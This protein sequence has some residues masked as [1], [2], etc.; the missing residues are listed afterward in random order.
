MTCPFSSHVWISKSNFLSHA[1]DAIL[2]FLFVCYNKFCFYDFHEDPGSV[3]L[4]PFFLQTMQSRECHPSAWNWYLLKTSNPGTTHTIWQPCLSHCWNCLHILTIGCLCHISLFKIHL[5]F[6]YHKHMLWGHI[7]LCLPICC[8][9]LGSKTLENF[10]SR[11]K[12]IRI[13]HDRVPAK[14][15]TTIES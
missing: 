8:L 7:S 6:C 14:A 1:P 3:S 10:C 11:F 9:A 13:Y 4:L 2:R 15:T 12:K 5:S